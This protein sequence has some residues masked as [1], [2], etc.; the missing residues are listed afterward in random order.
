MLS[1]RDALSSSLLPNAFPHIIDTPGKIRTDIE[2][3]KERSK[4][5]LESIS[6]IVDTVIAEGPDGK[7]SG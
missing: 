1:R 4:A 2:G 3:D 5:T 6:G 7:L